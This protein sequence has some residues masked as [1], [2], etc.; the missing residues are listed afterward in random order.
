MTS[1]GVVDRTRFIVPSRGGGAAGRSPGRSTRNRDVVGLAGAA[2]KARTC[3][4]RL[5]LTA[6][7]ERPT[8]AAESRSRRSLP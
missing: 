8:N 5:A 4:S 1:C 3:C 6:S 2:A 7:A